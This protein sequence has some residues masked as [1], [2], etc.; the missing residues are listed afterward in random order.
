MTGQVI[1]RDAGNTL[2]FTPNCRMQIR[3]AIYGSQPKHV[4]H[5]DEGL[6]KTDGERTAPFRRDGHYI[7][8]CGPPPQPPPSSN[9]TDQTTFGYSPTSSP[10]QT[11]QDHSIEKLSLCV[12]GLF[13][14]NSEL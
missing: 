14:W 8:H 6:T 9:S 5:T 10:P 2:R 7:V 11:G 1:E 13:L 4:R 12:D 3:T